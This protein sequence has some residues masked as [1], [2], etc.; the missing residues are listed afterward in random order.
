MKP[1]WILI[2]DASHARLLQQQ[3]DGT[4]L[5]LRA[6]QR[7]AH[8]REAGERTFGASAYAPAPEAPR[9]EHLRFALELATYLEQAASHGWC[10]SLRVFAPGPFLGELHAELGS[11]TQRLLAGCHDVDLSCAGLAEIA[12]RAELARKPAR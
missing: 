7:D 11:A 1:H 12:H 2:A 8:G 6:F 5:Q 9:K 10:R 4:V 3:P